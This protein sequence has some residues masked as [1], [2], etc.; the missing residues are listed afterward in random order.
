MKITIDTK[1]DSSEEIQ[2]VISL[3]SNIVRGSNREMES[4]SAIGGNDVF[5]DLD[6]VKSPETASE[7][8]NAF[9]SMFGETPK[10]E[11]TIDLAN[12]SAL[13]VE[14]KEVE[15]KEDVKVISY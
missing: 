1:E 15:E 10:E 7:N 9:A 3:L 13:R 4:K 2:K 5:G 6:K 12:L 8:Q 11:P 14:E